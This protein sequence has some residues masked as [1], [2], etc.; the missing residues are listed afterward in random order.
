M[1]RKLS[2]RVLCCLAFGPDPQIEQRDHGFH[3]AFRFIASRAG[4]QARRSPTRST[5]VPSGGPYV[6]MPERSRFH[7]SSRASSSGVDGT[8]RPLRG[9][10]MSEQF[11]GGQKVRS[12]NQGTGG[13]SES[14]RNPR[15]DSPERG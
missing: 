15:P 13:S 14:E 12:G 1:R 7:E 3:R 2:G 11:V 6:P 8:L 4:S 10:G 9:G 5:N